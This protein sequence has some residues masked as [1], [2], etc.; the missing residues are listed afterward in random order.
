LKAFDK[1]PNIDRIPDLMINAENVSEE[2]TQMV[3]ELS[4]PKKEQYEYIPTWLA[5]SLIRYPDGRTPLTL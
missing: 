4:Y 1:Y 5:N 3:S 2:F